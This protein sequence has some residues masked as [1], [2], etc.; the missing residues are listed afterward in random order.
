MSP[1]AAASSSTSLGMGGRLFFGS[2]CAGTF[3]L[4]VWQTQRFF[5]KQ[6]LVKQRLEELSMHPQPMMQKNDNDDDNSQQQQ[7]AKRDWKRRIVT[8]IYRHDKEILVGPRGPPPGVLAS[9]GPSS[10]RSGG[11]GM[12]TSPQ[13]YYVWTP[14]QRFNEEDGQ[15]QP[16]PPP[17]IWINRGWI[18]R[19]FPDSPG[20]DG[21]NNDSWERPQ[22]LQTMI[23]VPIKGEKPRFMTPHHNF[24]TH[25]P[26]F[27]WMDVRAFFEYMGIPPPPNG[28][29]QPLLW[30][31]VRSEEKNQSS[32]SS[33]PV[34]PS[35]D[36]VGEIA[37][38][39]SVHAGYAVTWFGLSGAGLYMTRKLITRGR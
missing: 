12:S 3:G 7:S 23:V 4:G 34:K 37:L 5:E 13:G 33:F 19:H 24:Q 32:S 6:Q 1:A 27:F 14:L 17:P 28:Q 9:T 20:H 26:R 31:Q 21:G 35:T 38:T 30:M 8:G 36:T 15:T 22:G 10:G 25:P 16:Q 18:P 39:P 2:L 11:G 29:H